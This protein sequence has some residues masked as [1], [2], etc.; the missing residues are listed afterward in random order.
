MKKILMFTLLFVGIIRG[1][2]V[3]DEVVTK[4]MNLE[5]DVYL[6]NGTWGG[7]QEY[8][9]VEVGRFRTSNDQFVRTFHDMSMSIPLSNRDFSDRYPVGSII[10][11]GESE[12]RLSLIWQALF[13]VQ[14]IKVGSKFVPD[15]NMAHLGMGVV[16][17]SAFITYGAERTTEDTITVH[18]ETRFQDGETIIGRTGYTM[19]IN[20]SW[21]IVHEGVRTDLSGLPVEL[22]VLD[23]TVTLARIHEAEQKI[24][25]Y[26]SVDQEQVKQLLTWWAWRAVET[27]PNRTGNWDIY[28]WY[29]ASDYAFLLETQG[30]LDEHFQY[31]AP[32]GDI[33][34]DAE[35]NR[36]DIVNIRNHILGN[37]DLS[38]EAFLVADTNGDGRVDIFD[39]MMIRSQIFDIKRLP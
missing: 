1:Q 32:V 11:Y 38:F 20:S 9:E 34:G 28:D 22:T 39:I 19:V 2:V 14:S 8:Y 10:N 33:N 18:V 29:R 17:I 21:E 3:A 4:T 16:D 25:N 23:D 31:P 35:I 12:R 26:V 24:L 27:M 13:Q 30:K 15:M 5:Q 36:L 37:S 7:E 6:R